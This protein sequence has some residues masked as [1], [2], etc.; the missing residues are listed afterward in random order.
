MAKATKKQALGRGLSALL[1]DPDNDTRIKREATPVECK[2]EHQSNP[3]CG[4]HIYR[5]GRA[6]SQHPAS[7]A[8][9]HFSSDQ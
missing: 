6:F 4:A 3:A 1:N 5:H 7:L 9:S 8:T 2:H